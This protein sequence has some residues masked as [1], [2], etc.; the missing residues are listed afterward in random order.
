M[1]QSTQQLLQQ[2]NKQYKANTLDIVQGI[3][4][5]Q[6]NKYSHILYKTTR[7]VEAEAYPFLP[8]TLEIARRTM[9]ENE[10]IGIAA[11]QMGLG[12]Q[13]FMIEAEN[14]HNNKRYSVETPVKF[15]VFINPKIVSASKEFNNF[16]HGCLSAKG[17]PRGKVSTY[18]WI[19]FE[20]LDAKANKIEGKLQDLAAIIFQH[21][22]R[23][24]LGGLY[25]DH[26]SNLLSHEKLSDAI[27]RGHE[28]NLTK[29]TVCGFGNKP[30]YCRSD[31]TC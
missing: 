10:G 25:I 3:F 8:E 24:L 14:S 29:S 19:E 28:Q 1:S 2:F 9:H 16:W 20:A 13:F 31:R 17:K 4:S 18:R 6:Y 22:F 26:S 11:N 7:K 5:N 21:E 27:K 12:L 15:Q 30:F 23:H